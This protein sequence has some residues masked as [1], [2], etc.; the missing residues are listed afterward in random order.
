MAP[1]AALI[2]QAVTRGPLGRR[3]VIRP[4]GKGS[5]HLTR[6]RRVDYAGRWEIE[7]CIEALPLLLSLWRTIPVGHPSR[8]QGGPEA[9]RV[10]T[11]G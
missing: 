7:C 11:S 9:R 3:H 1:I 8:H 6:R 10:R 2:G 5:R 4:I